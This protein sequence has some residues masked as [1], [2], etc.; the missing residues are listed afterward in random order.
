[1]ADPR[2]IAT[3]MRHPFQA[4]RAGQGVQNVQN[5]LQSG[6]PRNPTPQDFM[7]APQIASQLFQNVGQYAQQNPQQVQAGMRFLQ[8]YLTGR[9]PSGDLVAEK[10]AMKDLSI[11]ELLKLVGE[12]NLEEITINDLCWLALL[13]KY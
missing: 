7:R 10:E 8:N 3:I 5:I 13:N 2:L 1:M 12:V 9:M 6:I 11:A 4:Y